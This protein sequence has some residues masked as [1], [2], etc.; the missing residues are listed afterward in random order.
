[1]DPLSTLRKPV[2]HMYMQ[3]NSCCDCGPFGK[4]LWVRIYTY[5]FTTLVKCSSLS[6]FGEEGSPAAYR[7]RVLR[8]LA[9]RLAPGATPPKPGHNARTPPL[10]IGQVP[11][12]TS[13]FYSGILVELRHRSAALD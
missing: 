12:V 4:P 2:V 6:A 9:P 13:T 11:G 5:I 3:V 7:A 10:A 8:Y 1:M